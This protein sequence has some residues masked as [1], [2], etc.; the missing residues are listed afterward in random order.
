ME[1]TKTL[2]KVFLY[3][4]L[5]RFNIDL[6]TG[7]KTE[8][9]ADLEEAKILG[10]ALLDGEDLDLLKEFLSK[11]EGNFIGLLDETLDSIYDVY[12]LFNFDI[13]FLSSIP[14]EVEREVERLDLVNAL[15]ERLTSLKRLLFDTCCS[16][17]RKKTLDLV[18][19]P[20]RVY[21]ELIDHAIEF[22]K[23]FESR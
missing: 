22:N 16:P 6:L 7:I 10:E 11:V 9:R 8:I 12:E 17:Q 1:K 3:D 23:K 19:T 18:L 15:N 2:E 4:R 14:E 13:T 20:F 5:L 21:C